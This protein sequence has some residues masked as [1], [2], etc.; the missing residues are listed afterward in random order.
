MIYT[1][2]YLLAQE[3]K[4]NL[5]KTKEN[6]WHSHFGMI[7]EE[8]TALNGDNVVQSLLQS[9]RWSTWTMLV[10]EMD[11]VSRCR[12]WADDRE[13]WSRVMW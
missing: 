3:Q 1:A 10:C 5:A 8:I 12:V 6:L 7:T 9:Y 11:T 13:S 4:Y 2:L